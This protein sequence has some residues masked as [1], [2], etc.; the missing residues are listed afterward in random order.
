MDIK[1]F[2]D[3]VDISLTENI[4]DTNSF[5]NNIYVYQKRLPDWKKADIAIIGLVEDRG[6]EAGKNL[7]Q[8]A[9]KVRGQ[10]YN[11][12]KGTGHYKIV[13]L[14]NLRVG[15]N[16]EE[17]YLRL[18]EICE[19]LLSHEVLPLFIGGS[20]DMDLGQFM[21][22]QKFEKLINVVS[23][24][25]HFDMDHEPSRAQE[26]HHNHRMIVH[27]PN[28]LFNFAHLASQE[29]HNDN[30]ISEIFAKLHFEKYRLGLLRNDISSVEPVVRNADMLSFDMSALKNHESNGQ[31]RPFGL[32]GEEACQ[33]CWYAG[34]SHKLSSIGFYGYDPYYDLQN[35]YCQTLATM[36]WYVIEGF[37]NRKND[38][39]FLGKDFAKFFVSFSHEPHEI[40]FY[41]S[42][43]TEKWWIEVPYPQQKEKFAK[44]SIVPCSYSD[45]ELA[46]KGELPTRWI[47]THAKLF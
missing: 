10:L 38:S 15:I 11:L 44:V 31:N 30:D 45:Y 17:S 21:G 42:L 26:Y 36:V 43:K 2:F 28:F 6:S 37:Y 41:K 33:I 12:K 5:F 34:F 7:A 4:K 46:L 29:F 13:D 47:N 9:N 8:A 14:G 24:D 35:L 1:I 22:Y 18:K 40:T 3:S 16:L 23:V 19:I 32:S 39:D 25:Y 20:H 27:E